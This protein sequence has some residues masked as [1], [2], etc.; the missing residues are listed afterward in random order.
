MVEGQRNG[1]EAMAGKRTDGS[2]R[3]GVWRERAVGA[4]F[5]LLYHNRALYWLA[6]TVPFA[7][8]WRVWQRRAIP[9]IRG[10]DVLEVGCGL[11][12]LLMDMLEAGYRC[13]AVDAS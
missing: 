7:G 12:T 2:T 1:G 8:Q 6:S 9:R 11:G 13:H 4:A 10:N 5:E 3:R